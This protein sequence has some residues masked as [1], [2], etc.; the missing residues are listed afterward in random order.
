MTYAA[1]RNNIKKIKTIEWI[2]P[3]GGGLY[4]I[5]VQIYISNVLTFL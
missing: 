4:K 1:N 5:H 2:F 3:G